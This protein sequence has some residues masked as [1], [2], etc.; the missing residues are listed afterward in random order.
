MLSDVIHLLQDPSEGSNGVTLRGNEDWTSLI[1]EKGREYPVNEA[2]YVVLADGD[3]P[4]GDDKEM[5]EARDIFL[6]NGHFAPFV[7]AVTKSVGDAVEASNI[8]VTQE[9]ALC[10]VGA[11]TGYYLSHTLD[12]VDQS[13]GVAIDVSLPAAEKLAHCHPRVGAVVA[14]AMHTLP[15][16]SESVDVISAI[17]APRNPAEFA[18]VLKDGGELVV[19]ASHEGHLGELRAPLEIPDVRPHKIEEIIEQVSDYFAVVDEPRLVE[20]PMTLD[21]DSILAQIAMSPSAQVIDQEELSRRAAR[22]PQTMTVTARS[23]ITRLKK[24]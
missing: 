8:P 22:L 10:E 3:L 18:R 1:S 23:T 15:L 19:L 4:A 14:D 21:H 6:A 24:K 17:F 11:G 16:L 20:F 12:S 5:V 13:V 7:E 2:G 9:V